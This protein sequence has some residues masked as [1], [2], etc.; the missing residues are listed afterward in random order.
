MHTQTD[1]TEEILPSKTRRARQGS[2]EP[3]HGGERMTTL[4]SVKTSKQTLAANGD[5]G[6]RARLDGPAKAMPAPSS[7]R[8]FI[9]PVPSQKYIPAEP[10]H[11][12]YYQNV[13]EVYSGEDADSE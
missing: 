7:Q 6:S 10:D 9:Q 5:M 8:K 3:H 12:P 11:R 13:P 1:E 2:V 4:P